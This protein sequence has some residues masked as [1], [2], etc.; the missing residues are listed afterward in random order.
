MSDPRIWFGPAGTEIVGQTED[1]TPIAA[2]VDAGVGPMTELSGYLVDVHFT[3]ADTRE[4][5]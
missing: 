1:G 3:P 2:G 5:T 4:E